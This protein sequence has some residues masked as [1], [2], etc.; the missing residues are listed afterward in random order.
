MIVISRQEM[1]LGTIIQIKN[2]LYVFSSE[3]N[4]L[5]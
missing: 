5:C 4:I 2:F 3:S 1:Y